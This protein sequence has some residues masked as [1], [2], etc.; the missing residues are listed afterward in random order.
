MT[1]KCKDEFNKLSKADT[2]KLRG[3]A[4]T[5]AVTGF[6]RDDTK[7]RPWLYPIYMGYMVVIATPLPFLGAG[8]VVLAGTAAWAK[9]GTSDRAKN[10][11]KRITDSYQKAALYREYQ[12]VI[13]P[14]P[15]EAEKLRVNG[16]RLI[17]HTAKTAAN[18]GWEA[19]KTAFRALNPF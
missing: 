3:S 18:D 16:W 12:D 19:T 13:E 6:V 9:Y 17:G 7:E 2:L 8:A 4:L 1:C 15:E 5:K 10:L 11:Q 14:H